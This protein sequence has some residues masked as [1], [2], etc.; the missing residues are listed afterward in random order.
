[1]LPDNGLAEEDLLYNAVLNS[2]VFINYC[3]LMFTIKD[4]NVYENKIVYFQIILICAIAREP[5]LRDLVSI[6]FL[7][8]VK[9]LKEG[10]P[11]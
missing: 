3:I 2:C 5:L 11:L 9:V 8:G 7:D 10:E 6:L 4:S 1:M